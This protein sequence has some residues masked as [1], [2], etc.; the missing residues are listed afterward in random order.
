[1]LGLG[2]K[3]A[4][5]TVVGKRFIQENVGAYFEYILDVQPADGGPAFRTTLREPAHLGGDPDPGH[6]VQAFCKPG[7]QTV[8]FDRANLQ[9]RLI[10]DRN[11][12]PPGWEADL[13]AAPGTPAH[14]HAAPTASPTSAPVSA[15]GRRDQLREVTT[16]D[17]Q[18][19]HGTPVGNGRLLDGPQHGYR[20]GAT[21]CGISGQEIFVMRHMFD[22]DGPS[23]CAECAAATG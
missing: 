18:P 12:Q 9:R 20:D 14:T 7:T 11:A 16:A 19:M 13:H 21:L 22:P 3:P 2:W 6:V 17:T 15:A 23:A 5:A 10:T 1:M 8:K 4:Q